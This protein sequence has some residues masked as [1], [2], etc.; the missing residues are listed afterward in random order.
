M[1]GDSGVA[2]LD[3][4]LNGKGLLRHR[5]DSEMRACAAI[6]LGRVGTEAAVAAL[7]KAAV[8]RDVI[9][10]NAVARALRGETRVGDGAGNTE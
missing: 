3:A 9:V 4:L 2:L 6:A 5:E 1:C 10:R 8:E 7:R